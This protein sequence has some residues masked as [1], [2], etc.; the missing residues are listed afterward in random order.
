MGQFPHEWVLCVTKGSI[1]FCAVLFFCGSEI[2][3]SKNLISE[4]C[5]S[6]GNLYSADEFS[7]KLVFSS[8]LN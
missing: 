4:R 6:L 8:K 7:S 5:V 2:F 3:L 1:F